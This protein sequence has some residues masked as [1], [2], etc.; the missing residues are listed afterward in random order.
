MFL[1]G[2][3]CPRFVQQV[4]YISKRWTKLFIMC[5]YALFVNHVKVLCVNLNKKHLH[6][7]CQ[8]QTNTVHV[9]WAHWHRGVIC[10][11]DFLLLLHNM[12]SCINNVSQRRSCTSIIIHSFCVHWSSIDWSI[13]RSIHRLI[14]PSINSL[15]LLQDIMRSVIKLV[16]HLWNIYA[17]P[18]SRTTPRR[19]WLP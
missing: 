2:L 6:K 7:I 9:L 5:Q 14:H 18:C 1:V 11:V 4:A 16:H 13:H 8:L 12:C 3:R 19:T 10:K 15:S 17:K